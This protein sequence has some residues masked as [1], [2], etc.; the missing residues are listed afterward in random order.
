[1]NKLVF[2][3]RHPHTQYFSIERLF[4]K[5]AAHLTDAFPHE[6]TIVEKEM[7]FQSKINKIFKNIS[8]TRRQQ[9]AVNHITGD[10]QYTILGWSRHNINILTIHDCVALHRYASTNPKH[11]FIKLLW[12]SWPVKK[13]DAVTVISEN[14]RRE[15]LEFTHCDP[16][17]IRVIPNFVDPSFQY[18]SFVFNEKKPSIL[19]IGTTA[20]KNL[21]RLIEALSGIPATLDIIGSLSG[22]QIKKLETFHID[23]RQSEK[24][25][26]AALLE[27]YRQ[28]DIVAFPSTYEGFGLPI[29]EAQ[30][31]GR[32]VLTSN[33]SPMKE[34]AG[35]GARLVNPYD[36][37]SIREGILQIINDVAYREKIIEE[38]LQNIKHFSIESVADQ[39]AN[40]YRE[41]L[42][43][44][45]VNKNQ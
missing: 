35:A 30:A 6:F 41:L 27:K 12:Y 43:K 32:P 9:A 5:I 44:K 18:S 29:V 37:G 20:N 34:V 40:L 28:C 26:D 7:P 16:A 42:Q 8:F 14:T 10:I 33:L 21:D 15:I 38:G 17:K 25:G 24:L 11:W 45:T 22:K 1:M 4:K 13:A 19:F 36:S 2:F 23:Y 3:Y 31:T 39:Y